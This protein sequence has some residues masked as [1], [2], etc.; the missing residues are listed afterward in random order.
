MTYIFGHPRFL[1]CGLLVLLLVCGAGALR[2]QTPPASAAA[3]INLDPY[4]VNDPRFTRDQ[5]RPAASYKIEGGQ[6]DLINLA[7][8]EDALKYAPNVFVRKRFIGDQNGALT[9]RGTHTAQSARSLVLADGLVLSNF[10]GSGHGFSPRWGL[11]APEEIESVEVTY[12]PYSSLYG[13][14]SL[15]GV[16]LFTTG[17]PSGPLATAKASF[18]FNDYNQYGTD[19]IFQGNQAAVAV[20]NRSGRFTWFAFYNRL[21]NESNPT[22][23]RT[24]LQAN[25]TTAPGGTPVTG[26]ISDPDLLERRASSPAPPA[27][28][29]SSR[30]S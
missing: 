15:G 23:F 28:R 20:G 18:F 25:T 6:L 30:T 12:G 2:A 16:V 19:K 22:D 14:N 9:V 17:F 7:N 10:L 8:T 1:V 21:K 5:T 29:T 4:E 27:S 11:V 26:A 24:L 3:A 13:G